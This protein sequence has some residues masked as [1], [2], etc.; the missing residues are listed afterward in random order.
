VIS[1]VGVVFKGSGFYVTDNRNGKANSYLNSGKGEG[2]KGDGAAGE[3]TKSDSAQSDGKADSGT[4]PPKDSSS[5][6]KPA[7]SAS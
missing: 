6:Q 7:A 2:A 5:S 3:G 1:Q 4:T